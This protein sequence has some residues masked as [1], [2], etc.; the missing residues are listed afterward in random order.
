MTTKKNSPQLN[1]EI[2]KKLKYLKQSKILD[3][4]AG[5]LRNKLDIFSRYGNKYISIDVK[6]SGFKNFKNPDKFFDGENIPYPKNSFDVVIFTE[7]FEHAKNVD[8][9]VL[10]IKRV[11]K[12]NGKLI[13]SLPFL[14]PEHEIPYD[15]R[16]LTSYG[17]KYYF[18]NKGFEIL[19]YKK[20]NKGIDALG[21][22]ISSEMTKSNFKNY[23]L[24]KL[25]RYLVKKLFN[26]LTKFYSFKNCYSG[27][28]AVLK[29]SVKI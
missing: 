18:A 10:D 21:Y 15:F 5:D 1:I 22:I 4:G 8:Q 25:F 28:F 7:V 24:D 12:K 13:F 11:L 23:I 16:R 9:L 3:V 26:V 20:I 2:F 29:K 27:S 17:L 6:K 14:W 19:Y